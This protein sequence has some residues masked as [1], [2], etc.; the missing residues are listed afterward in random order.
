MRLFHLH[1][2]PKLPHYFPRHLSFGLE[3]L[4]LFIGLNDLA[5]AAITLFEPI[6][7]ISLGYSLSRVALFWALI[8][9]VYI[10]IIPFGAM[11]TSRY[12]HARSIFLSSL[13]LIFYYVSL[14]SLPLHPSFFWIAI[15]CLALYKTFYWPALEADFIRFANQDQ[16]GK[17]LSAVVSLS[18]IVNVIGPLVGGLMI[19]LFGFQA[20]FGFV[21]AL[22]LLANLPLAFSHNP[23]TREP[24]GFRQAWRWLRAKDRRRTFVAYLGYGEE[25]IAMVF[26]PLAIFLAVRTYTGTGALVA[27]ATLFTALV[28]LYIGKLIDQHRQ[29]QLIAF[30]A[31][32]TS[33]TWFARVFAFAAWPVFFLDTLA[34][35]F[36]SFVHV[37]TLEL[38]FERGA[39]E[40][41]LKTVVFFE[42]SLAV[43]KLLI[44]GLA[45]ALFHWSSNLLWIF[46]VA[47]LFA[48]FYR[49]QLR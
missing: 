2:H 9:L 26:W 45:V 12:G 42:Q 43:G 29:G 14:F 40:G 25:L 7:L 21:I 34:R 5:I 36:K 30:G 13:F 10:L 3:E 4:Y 18:T 27:L 15:L 23:P 47:G 44:A 17:E 16:E 28:T 1:L 24:V 20:L 35:V 33:V 19:K 46:P 41:P 39:R 8:Y 22:V 11:V 31:T 37:P 32:A 6:Y 49:R 48:L 38:A